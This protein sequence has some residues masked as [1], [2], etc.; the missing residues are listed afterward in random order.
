MI[1]QAPGWEMTP[2]EMAK[3]G[4]VFR[5]TQGEFEQLSGKQK[6]TEKWRGY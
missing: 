5:L 6:K 4:L 3:H 1:T 2:K